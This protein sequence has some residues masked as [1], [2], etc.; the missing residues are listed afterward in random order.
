M[1]KIWVQRKNTVLSFFD[2][3]RGRGEIQCPES[4]I[5]VE[6]KK[7]KK[8]EETQFKDNDRD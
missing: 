7:N 8:Q 2:K 4:G 3:M 6:P 5:A 1:K